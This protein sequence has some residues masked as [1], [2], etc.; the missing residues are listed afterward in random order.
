MK[1]PDLYVGKRLFVGEGN[2]ISLGLGP[3]EVRGSSFIEGPLAIGNAS[4]FPVIPGALMVAPQT[5]PDVKTPAF[6]SAYFFG[7]VSTVSMMWIT[8]LLAITSA[9]TTN[10]FST[11]TKSPA[12]ASAKAPP[13]TAL[14]L[15]FFTSLEDTAP[16]TA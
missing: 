7:G 16:E 15:L 14:A 5:N 4:K 12:L 10:A 1:V 9:L 3:T 2:P 8:P 11:V 13:L 6:W